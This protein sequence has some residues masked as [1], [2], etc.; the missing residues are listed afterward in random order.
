MQCVEDV[1]D[2]WKVTVD[3]TD[4]VTDEEPEGG[5]EDEQ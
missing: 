4:E 3:G 1:E 5:A 2:D